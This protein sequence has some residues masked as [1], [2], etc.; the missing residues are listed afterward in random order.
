MSAV[1]DKTTY[2]PEELLALP[3]EKNYELVDGR[4]VERNMSILSSWVAGELH[5]RIRS[6]CQAAAC[7]WAFPEGTGFTC[8]PAAP[9]LMRKPDVSFIRNERMPAAAWNE[10]YCSIVPDLVVEVVSPHDLSWE[11]EQKLREW[12]TA[13][14]PLV[15]VVHPEVRGVRVHRGDGRVSELN[16]GDE[17]SGEEILPGFRCRVAEIFPPWAE[18]AAAPG[19][20]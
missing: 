18:A 17:L 19:R 7:G 2:T 3:D 20:P 12:L 6:H 15:W 5:F 13:G 11:V 1:A 4:L 8:F 16:V 9:R 14:V 10:G